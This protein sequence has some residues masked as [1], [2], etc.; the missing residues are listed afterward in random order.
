MSFAALCVFTY[1]YPVSLSRKEPQRSS[2]GLNTTRKFFRS[3]HAGAKKFLQFPGLKL[4]R[5]TMSRKKNFF[6]QTQKEVLAHALFLGCTVE[7]LAYI[8]TR[9]ECL[10]QLPNNFQTSKGTPVMDVMRF[11]HGDG[12]EQQIESG[13]Q[14]GG[15]NFSSGCSGDSRRYHDLLRSFTSPHLSLADRA[16]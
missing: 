9:Q 10:D 13:E 4:K 1:A 5:P 2:C 12:P 15:N 6:L 7:Q 11:F 3:Y 14:R 16:A 8:D